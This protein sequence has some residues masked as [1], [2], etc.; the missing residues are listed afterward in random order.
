MAPLIALLSLW[1]DLVLCLSS[2]N[3]WPS[4]EWIFSLFVLWDF[5]LT[6]KIPKNVSPVVHN[7]KDCPKGKFG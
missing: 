1:D 4:A 7:L 2:S 6:R 5:A 3:N